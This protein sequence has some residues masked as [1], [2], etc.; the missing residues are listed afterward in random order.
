M[1]LNL[2]VLKRYSNRDGIIIHSH[3]FY[4]DSVCMFKCLSSK[5]VIKQNL[6]CK[7]NC[8]FDWLISQWWYM[9]IK[10]PH[11]TEQTGPIAHA[12]NNYKLWMYLNLITITKVIDLSLYPPGCTI[13][14]FG[15]QHWQATQQL[16]YVVFSK[17][18]YIMKDQTVNKALRH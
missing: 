3:T 2:K 11:E 14:C 17:C 13:L 4:I 8:P 16:P 10:L 18:C 5:S 1:K 7:F 15:Y 6:T 12:D 9:T